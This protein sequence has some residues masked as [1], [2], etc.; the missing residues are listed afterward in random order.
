MDTDKQKT[1][2]RW[3]AFAREMAAVVLGILIALGLQQLVEARHTSQQ[4]EEAHR[5]LTQ[6]LQGMA[7][8]ATRRIAVHPCVERRLQE[9]EAVLSD[10]DHGVRVGQVADFGR[11]IGANNSDGVWRA[12]TSAGVLAH[13]RTDELVT[14]GKIYTI[15]EEIGSWSTMGGQDW[16]TIK[17]IVGDADRLTLSDRSMIRVA[18]NHT[19]ALEVV[20]TRTMPQQLGRARKLGVALSPLP[21]LSAAPECLPLKRG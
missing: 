9:V 7:A 21:D 2:F 8:N 20:W 16:S 11:P 3:R 5:A 10:L 15:G 12:L 1:P 6:E 17:L 19:R 14:Y 13:F 18:I 4:V